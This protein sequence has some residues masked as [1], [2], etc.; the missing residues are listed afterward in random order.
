MSWAENVLAKLQPEEQQL[1]PNHKQPEE[2]EIFSWSKNAVDR[3]NT[4][5]Q[6]PSIMRIHIDVISHL[7]D[8]MKHEQRFIQ[9]QIRAWCF[10]HFAVNQ[11]CGCRRVD[12]HR[13]INPNVGCM[14]RRWPPSTPS[15]SRCF[16]WAV[17]FERGADPKHPWW[18]SEERLSTSAQGRTMDPG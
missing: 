12:G 18:K 13:W 16:F 8:P 11:R 15:R 3:M 14:A 7:G 10:N 2:R 4:S 9:P 5:E 6:V 1:K 17:V